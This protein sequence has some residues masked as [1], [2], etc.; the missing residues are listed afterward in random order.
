MAYSLPVSILEGSAA[1]LA[2]SVGAQRLAECCHHGG[3]AVGHA[4]AGLEEGRLAA[5]VCFEKRQ[6]SGGGC[7]ADTFQHERP[8]KLSD[9]ISGCRAVLPVSKIGGPEIKALECWDL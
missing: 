2:S 9:R 7:A 4:V 3:T 1:Y 6:Q 8:G 5:G